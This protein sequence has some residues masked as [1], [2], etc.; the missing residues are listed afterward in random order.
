MVDLWLLLARDHEQ[1]DRAITRLLA[2]E[3]TPD[4][5]GSALDAARVGF[6]A[7]A[8]GEA[9]VLHS[10]LAHVASPQDFAGLVAQVLAAHRTQESILRRM[11][12]TARCTDWAGAAMRLRRSL[13]IHAEHE[14]T[15]VMRALRACLP[16]V[17]YQ[18]LAGAY[19]TEKM[20]ALGVMTS[21]LPQRRSRRDTAD[22]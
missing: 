4:E 17:E 12:P 8:D 2:A 21:L 10:A 1:L 5:R 6:A 11:D 16:V 7:H 20:R 14:R 18:R 3:A 19:A 13:V 15:I 9:K 22:A